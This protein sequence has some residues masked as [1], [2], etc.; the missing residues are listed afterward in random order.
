MRERSFSSSLIGS[1]T[2]G[3][4]SHTI[5]TIYW[6][7]VYRLTAISCR[8]GVWS[9]PNH[10]L[11]QLWKAPLHFR[12]LW[13]WTCLTPVWVPGGEIWT[14]LQRWNMRD[15]L[16]CC[17]EFR[18]NVFFSKISQHVPDGMY[19]I[20]VVGEWQWWFSWGLNQT[21][22]YCCHHIIQGSLHFFQFFECATFPFFRTAMVAW[23]IRK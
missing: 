12:N 7:L 13:I 1:L 15:G 21:P 16:T 23:L 9:G 20:H 18:N 22:S 19:L 2:G 5:K 14:T 3:L 6:L 10:C 11:H 4:C 8:I 17:L